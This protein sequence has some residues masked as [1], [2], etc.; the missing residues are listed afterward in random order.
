MRPKIKRNIQI[1]CI[2]I[3]VLVVI[4]FAP[5]I[6]LFGPPRLRN[7]V[8]K[9]LVYKVIATKLTR[10][11]KSDKEKAL[12]LFDYVHTHL[13]PI[14]AEVIDKHPLNDMI[15]GIAWCDQQA[16]M[17]ITLAR[18]VHIKGRLI[19]LRGYDKISHHSICSLY[20]D[21]K[22]RVLDP[23]HG[24]VFFANGRNIA[25]FEDIQNSDVKIKSEQ[26]D[27]I[28]IFGKADPAT[29]FTTYE[30]AAYFRLYE[31]T[32]EP[33]T[34]RSNYQKDL[35]RFLLAKLINFYYDI[36]GDAFLISIQEI[37]FKL[38]HT[39]LFIK[40]RLKH[41][42]FR[43]NSAIIDY[44]YVM[45]TTQDNFIKSESIFFK[46]QAFWDR[47]YYNNSILE[48]QKLLKE[49]PETRWKEIA[50]FYLGNSYES[51]K[52]FDKAKFYYSKIAQK[53]QTPAPANLMKLI[54]RP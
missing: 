10:G 4:F 42:S 46:G 49:F 13:F 24:F 17:V 36:F 30:P 35:K 45:K 20:I 51:N 12:E 5:F 2:T 41:L 7:Y 52:E 22:Y 28:Q 44:D 23:Y 8:H 48:L 1:L 26:F 15:R 33:V 16:N 40:A 54:N 27:A 6:M 32:Y 39:D 21:G 34:F 25:S 47:R 50:L 3:I 9:E 19:F 37:Y 29:Y 14:K 31:K 18:K 43:F 38:A 53:C 11:I